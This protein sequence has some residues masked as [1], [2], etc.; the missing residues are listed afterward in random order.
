MKKPLLEVRHLE[1]VFYTEEGAVKAVDDVSFTIHEEETVCIVGE[2]GCGKSM[3]SLSIMQLI[4]EAGR[5]EQGA[6]HFS[7]RNLLKL[8]QKEMQKIRGCEIGMIFQEPMTSLNPVFTI[9]EQL[10][11]PIR[12]HL[13]LSKKEAWR[14]A[15]DLLTLVEIPHAGQMM[16]RYPHELSGGMLQRVMTAVALSCDPKL[17]IAD[18][19]TTALDVTIQ[20]QIL[21]LLR[22]VKKQFHTSILFITHDLGVVAEMADYVIVMYAGKIVEEGPVA[23]LFSDPKH[24]YTKGL[25]AAKPV[26]GQ[27]RETLYTIP[28]QVP[29]L[30]DL[31]ESSCY[32]AERCEHSTEICRRSSPHFTEFGKGHQAACWLYGEEKADE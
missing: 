3:A 14:K 18:E 28:G 19:P 13:L 27:R 8:K 7:G 10:T 4:P 12:E 29:A 26:I 15:V 32:F 25:L 16:H 21:D 2:S 9:G 20:A 31:S 24:P 5:I 11:E 1:T 17:I 30:A 22:D 6:V 23:E